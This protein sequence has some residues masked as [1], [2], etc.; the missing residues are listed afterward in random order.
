MNEPDKINLETYKL[1]VQ[2]VAE[3]PGVEAMGNQLCQLM[4][5]ALGVKG[6][7]LFVLDPRQAELAI[8]ASA[9]LST[10]YTQKGPILVDANIDLRANRET[11]VISNTETTNQLQ[12]P[13]KAQAEG[14]GAIVSCPI[15]ARTKIVGAMRL[16]NATPWEISSGD[17]TYLELLTHT[18]GLALMHSRIATAL[19]AVKETVG[20]I[21][22]VWL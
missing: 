9:G 14:V 11:V 17:L 1:L 5:G 7:T 2:A 19:V 12:Y 20:D 15:K 6:A 22:P 3:S 13:E 10:D 4:V 21:H 18:I 16:Y 8:L